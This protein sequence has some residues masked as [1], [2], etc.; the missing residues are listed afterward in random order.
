MLK[1]VTHVNVWVRDQD[2]A[3]EFYT[4]KLGFEVRQDVTLEE[5]GGFRWLTVGPPSQPDLEMI[6]MQPDAIP[7]SPDLEAP[8][9]RGEG[10]RRRRHLRGRGLPR[11]L[12]R[13]EGQGR[14]V[15]AGADRAVLRH[16]CGVPRPV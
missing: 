3:R 10:R 11:D 16:R 14:R 1:A 5:M 9:R 12:R 13:A 2:E 8:G 7:A 15:R 6:L 4:E